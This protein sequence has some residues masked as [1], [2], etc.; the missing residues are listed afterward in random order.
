MT[1]VYFAFPSVESV[2]EKHFEKQIESVE[3]RENHKVVEASIN[4]EDNVENKLRPINMDTYI[5][6]KALKY[7]KQ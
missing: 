3:N 6:Q 7:L 5:G 4:S 2:S 1:I